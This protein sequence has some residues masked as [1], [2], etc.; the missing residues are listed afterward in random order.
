MA[1][2]DGLFVVERGRPGPSPLVVLVHGTMDR[3]AGMAKVGR[4]L[5]AEHVVRYDRRGYGRSCRGTGVPFAGHVDDLLGVIDDRRAVVVGHS[6]GGVVAL[7]AAVVA[8]DR[9]VAVVAFEAP[10][11][12]EPWWP[13]T[14]AS[15]TAVRRA[16]SATDP[17]GAAEAFLRRMLGDARWEALPERTRQDRRREGLAMVTE[18][19]SLRTG[20]PPFDL[21]AIG[22]PVIAGR[23]T[24]SPAHLMKAAEVLA[25]EVPV[26]EL[27]VVEGAS[28]NAHM[29]HPAAV[30]ELAR[31]A[32]RRAAG[33]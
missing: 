21:A 3:S 12:W 31:R 18:A 9:V 11:P 8:P 29:S 15:S 32:L 30:A 14:T 27:A 13:S 10:M 20:S 22:T 2:P 7:G 28:H 23:G 26:G 33:R 1:P 16:D 4:H 5:A 17:G 19:A 25:S 6:Y 24:E